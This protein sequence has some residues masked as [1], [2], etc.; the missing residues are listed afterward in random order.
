[1]NVQII[2]STQSSMRCDPRGDNNA[3]SSVVAACQNHRPPA[4]MD[5]EKVLRKMHGYYAISACVEGIILLQCPCRKK[6]HTRQ[7]QGYCLAS[8]PF[9]QGTLFWEL[10]TLVAGVSSIIWQCKQEVQRRSHFYEN[11]TYSKIRPKHR[12]HKSR[13]I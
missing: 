1:M 13:T 4:H 11:W 10:P 3:T 6:K 2:L 9:L 8:A 12:E 7:N 5:K